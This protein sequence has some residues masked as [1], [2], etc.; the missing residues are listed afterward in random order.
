MEAW[1]QGVLSEG[2]VEAITANVSAATA[3]TYAAQ[4]AELVPHLARLS[5]ADVARVMRHWKSCAE[6]DQQPAEE[7]PQHL[8]LSPGLD[9]RWVLDGELNSEVGQ[10]VATALRV[11]ETPEGPGEEPRSAA[12]RRAD[13]LGD[14]CRF[15]LDHQR[16]R[17]AGR[18]RP[19]LNVVVEAADLAAGRA[20]RFLDGTTLSGSA[21]ARLACDAAVHRA[22]VEGSSTILDYGTSTRTIPTPLWNA[23]VVRDEHCRFPGCDRPAGW[24]D[25]HHVRWVERGG[26]TRLANLVLACRRHHHLLHTPGWDAHLDDDGT[27]TVT[28]PYGGVRTTAPPRALLIC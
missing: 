1:R 10:V 9:G 19:H 7:E 26:P 20:G 23:L 16:A 11:A 14:V 22:V 27:F 6:A 15:F 21:V 28:D 25:G 2:Q 24:C 12:W 17:P 8:H 5:V 18:H 4:E 13:A 3:A